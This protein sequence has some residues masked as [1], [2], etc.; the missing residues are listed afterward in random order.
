MLRVS[1]HLLIHR[2]SSAC[3]LLCL[4]QLDGTMRAVPFTL[5]RRCWNGA[6]RS[7]HGTCVPEIYHT[8]DTIFLF[9]ELQLETGSL[10]PCLRRS[11]HRQNHPV[12]LETKRLHF[13]YN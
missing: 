4:G 13:H 12:E 11:P 2:N 6:S 8:P 10:E 3:Y 1:R 9:V 7:W 5:G